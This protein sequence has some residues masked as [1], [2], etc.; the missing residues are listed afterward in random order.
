[1]D[2]DEANEKRTVHLRKL[3]GGSS[4]R[5]ATLHPW[6][7]L[8][9]RASEN[10][11]RQLSRHEY[12]SDPQTRPTLTLEAYVKSMSKNQNLTT[13]DTLD[14]GMDGLVHKYTHIYIYQFHT[15]T[16]IRQHKVY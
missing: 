8:Q 12:L 6:N 3:V 1:M 10:F 4:K 11:V 7:E 16:L 9:A 15:T 14:L 5:G 2:V 13:V